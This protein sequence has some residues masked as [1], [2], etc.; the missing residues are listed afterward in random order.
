MQLVQWRFRSAATLFTSTEYPC[1]VYLDWV[2]DGGSPVYLPLSDTI[3][4]YV[5]ML[6]S[7]LMPSW[8]SGSQSDLI[9]GVSFM[10]YLQ[11]RLRDF[12]RLTYLLDATSLRFVY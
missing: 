10:L 8:G 12:Y 1:Y 9:K 6:G 11:K 4:F 3:T 5:L 2:D 7:T